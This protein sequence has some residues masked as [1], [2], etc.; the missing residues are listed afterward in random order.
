MFVRSGEAL[1]YTRRHHGNCPKSMSG[2]DVTDDLQ[3]KLLRAERELERLRAQNRYLRDEI[4]A[5]HDFDEIIGASAG[6]TRVLENVSR[7]APTDAT[8]LIAGETGTGKELIARAIHATS[9]R[10]VGPFIKLDCAALRDQ[11]APLDASFALAQGGTIFLDEIGELQLEAQ[12]ELLRALQRQESDRVSQGAE[13]RIDVRIIAATNRDLRRLTHDAQFRED[14]YYRLNVFPVELPP[15]RARGE[16]IPLLV[17]FFAQ[18]YAPRVGRRVDGVDP[19]TL[20]ALTRYPWPG[21]VR[22]LENLVER[23]LI[24]NTSPMLKIPPEMLALYAPDDRGEMAAAATGMHRLPAFYGAPPIDL[25]NTESTGLHHVQR[26]HILRV[27]NATHWVIEGNSG[28]ALKLGMK[29]ATLRHRMK[30]LGIS[31]AQVA[32]TP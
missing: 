11:D 27:L 2:D 26:E 29:P 22:E 7:V 25:E 12:A 31:R 17:Q 19:D 10:S 8:V 23:A 13:G 20:A 24:M 3:Q 30:K 15:L 14:L 4:Q 16:D 21:N 1:P 28:A 32:P 6:L 5:V 18:K 9:R